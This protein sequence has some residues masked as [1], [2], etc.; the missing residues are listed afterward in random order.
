[1]NPGHEPLILR[2]YVRFRK[3]GT[4]HLLNGKGKHNEGNCMQSYINR[5]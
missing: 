4:Y 1:M 2:N 3:L 5:Q